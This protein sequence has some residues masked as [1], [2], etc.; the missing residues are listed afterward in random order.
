MIK[1]FQLIKNVLSCLELKV[2]ICFLYLM[3]DSRVSTESKIVLIWNLN[4]LIF[5]N[6]FSSPLLHQT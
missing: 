5:L 6:P 4:C 1:I 3:R 2:S